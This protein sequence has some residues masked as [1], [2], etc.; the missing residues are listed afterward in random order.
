MNKSYKNHENLHK[1][2]LKKYF[3]C[4]VFNPFELTRFT[5]HA[6]PHK[7]NIESNFSSWVIFA[8][9]LEKFWM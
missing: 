8:D 3:I 4:M 7:I 5:Q 2:F 9:T 6:F 1:Y